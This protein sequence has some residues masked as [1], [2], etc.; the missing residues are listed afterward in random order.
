MAT[1][2]KKR[3]VRRRTAANPTAERWRQL[4]HVWGQGHAIVAA[5]LNSVLSHYGPTIK[6]SPPPNGMTLQEADQRFWDLANVLR[7]DHP[8]EFNWLRRD[9]TTYLALWT[10]GRIADLDAYC[11][12]CQHRTSEPR[13]LGLNPPGYD[14]D[15]DLERN[16]RGLAI[17]LGRCRPPQSEI[18]YYI[19]R[20]IAAQCA[21]GESDSGGHQR[22]SG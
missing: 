20:P 11:V 21:N 17:T 22:L 15:A 8:I 5:R 13:F 1:R 9:G 6:A 12:E 7:A 18:T 3:V 4:G 2:K 10:V 16:A 14:L 19:V